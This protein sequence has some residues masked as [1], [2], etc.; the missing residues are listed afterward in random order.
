MTDA[1]RWAGGSPGAISRSV[2]QW[3]QLVDEVE[4][5]C[6]W[7]A[8]ELSNDLGCRREPAQAW[9][10]LPPAVRTGFDRACCPE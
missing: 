4:A 1:D 2:S 5:V 3:R 10:E 6:S 8:P 9:P 7:S